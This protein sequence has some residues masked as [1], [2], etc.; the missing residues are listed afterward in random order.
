MNLGITVVGDTDVVQG[1]A[2]GCIRVPPSLWSTHV[3]FGLYSEKEGL[4]KKK[5]PEQSKFATSS[6]S[7]V[8][9]I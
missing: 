2:R 9:R 6:N 4:A 3:S 1:K 5:E 8:C 7:G